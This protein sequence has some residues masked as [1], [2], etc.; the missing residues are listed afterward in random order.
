MISGQER[1]TY[2]SASRKSNREVGGFLEV[3]D[4]KPG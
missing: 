3:E 4:M 1:K 2:E